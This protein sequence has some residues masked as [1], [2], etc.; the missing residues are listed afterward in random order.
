MSINER[1]RLILDREKISNKDVA[2]W[3]G[4]TNSRLS[5]KFKEG[6]WDSVEELKLIT[7]RTGYNLDWIIT[8]KGAAKADASAVAEPELKLEGNPQ[9]NRGEFYKDLVEK[10]SDY[11][12]IPKAFINGDYRIMLKS[13]LEEMN[14]TREKLIESKDKSISLLEKRIEELERFIAT[15]PQGMK[16]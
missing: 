15:V 16:K 9:I 10:N 4:M 2:E 13:E 7:E 1:I 8:G 14:K 6:I 11:S 12:L 3:L 5:Q